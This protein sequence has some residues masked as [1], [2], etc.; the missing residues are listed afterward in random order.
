MTTAPTPPRSTTS[1]RWVT[2]SDADLAAIATAA[3]CR[4]VTVRR[5]DDL[6]IV[7]GWLDDPEPQPLVLDAKVNPD[8]CA[9]WLAE[10]FRHG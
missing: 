1:G 7:A 8:I 3:G 5:P 4:G 6:S 2:T 10:A 9:D